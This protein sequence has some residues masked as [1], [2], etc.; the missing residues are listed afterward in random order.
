MSIHEKRDVLLTNASVLLRPS[1]R[2]S[3][4]AE[5]LVENYYNLSASSSSGFSSLGSSTGVPIRKRTAS[6]RLQRRPSQV[7]VR[8]RCDVTK[9]RQDDSG[10]AELHEEEE[11]QESDKLSED[12]TLSLGDS[13]EE[14]DSGDED[15]EARTGKGKCVIKINQSEGSSS[16]TQLSINGCKRGYEEQDVSIWL[17]EEDEA[18]EAEGVL[19]WRC[20]GTGIKRRTLL[21]LKTRRRRK[22]TSGKRRNAA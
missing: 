4:G 19:V 6:C 8:T 5:G 16:S 20:S 1:S 7:L 13:E 3:E 10:F 22:R 21:V 2:L 9:I 18:A 12:S 15:N 17:E 14:E 11:Q